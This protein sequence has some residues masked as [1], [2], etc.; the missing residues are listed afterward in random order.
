M[1]CEIYANIIMKGYG[2]RKNSW[3]N[4][5][6]KLTTMADFASEWLSHIAT[7]TFY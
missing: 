6:A 7:I 1:F 3:D 5:M 2:F 4:L